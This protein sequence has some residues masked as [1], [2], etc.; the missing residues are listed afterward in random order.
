MA[1]NKI[2]NSKTPKIDTIKLIKILKWVILVV[3]YSY[4]IFLLINYDQYAELAHQ[5]SN[6]TSL[7]IL[8]LLLAII[9]LPVNLLVESSKWQYIVSKSQTLSAKNALKSVLL[10]FSTG[11]LTPNRAGDMLGRM[12]YLEPEN[13]KQ[14]VVYSLLNSY[15]LTLVL[16]SIGLP[17]SILLY[18]KVKNT[19]LFGDN[20]AFYF[21][22]IFLG[23]SVAILVYFVLPQILK[24]IKNKRIKKFS[25]GIEQFSKAN[26][27]YILLFSLLRYGVF[28]FQFY[29][30]LNFFG[31]NLELWQALIAIPAN[32]LFVTFTPSLAMSETAIRSSYAVI[33]IGIF[34]DQLI[35]IALAGTL[36]WLIN[37]GFPM[38]TGSYLLAKKS[39]I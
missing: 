17:A 14:G 28:C 22:V 36:I 2:T 34:S 1:E 13:R 30:I 6:T 26:L 5:L 8:W 23:I 31:V 16:A 21:W 32:Y 38:M 3:S 33:F 10:G 18:L 11:F 19:S 7:Q 20:M 15:T 25:I 29:A 35:N 27:M 39:K 12:T 37:Y 24:S 9:L 4:V